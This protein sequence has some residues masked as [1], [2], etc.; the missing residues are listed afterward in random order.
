MTRMRSSQWLSVGIALCLVIGVI[1]L[2]FGASLASAQNSDD[3]PT[4]N[5]TGDPNTVLVGQ[6]E[7]NITNIEIT[8]NNQI[9]ATDKISLYINLSNVEL[10]GVDV[11]SASLSV[12]SIQHGNIT[13]T[14]QIRSEDNTLLRATIRP[15]GTGRA[16]LVNT[17]R[18]SGID[19]SDAK[20]STGVEY[21]IAV[22]S[23][24]TSVPTKFTK[25]L[26]TNPFKIIDG[27]IEIH[28]QATA[29]P[30][31]HRDTRTTAGITIDN[32]SG[33]TNS[34]L[35][36]TR[37]NDN[38]I[39]G[40]RYLSEYVLRTNQAISVNTPYLGGD[41]KG[42]LVANSTLGSTDYDI[43]DHLPSNVT[44]SALSTSEGRIVTASVDLANRSYASSQTNKITIPNA[45]VSDTIEDKTPFFVSL[46]PVNSSGYILQNVT[47]ANSKVLTGW[48]ENVDLYFN[49]TNP[50][51]GIFRSN[52]YAAAIQLSRGLD[53]GNRVSPK[54]YELLRN[55]DLNNQFV[56]D[57]VADAGTILI[58]DSVHTNESN[59]T[60][61]VQIKH[62]QSLDKPV[63]AGQYL[64]YNSSLSDINN[65]ELH[66]IDNKNRSRVVS[67]GTRLNNSS[68][69]K[70]NTSMLTSGT[71]YIHSKRGNS[72][73]FRI[74]GKEKQNIDLQN[75]PNQTS[76]GNLIRF[77]VS[78]SVPSM[79]I[80]LD[81]T[82]N[83]TTT[84]L[85]LTTSE[86]GPT[87]V[88]INAYAS[89]ASPSDFVTTGPGISVD[90][91]TGDT[92]PLSPGS[93]DLTLRSEHGTEVAN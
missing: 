67:L 71:Y 32:I 82:T 27:T 79:E 60:V 59:S 23:G 1:V 89:P 54:N 4:L 42:F 91:V 14:S 76:N 38:E 90:S 25:E 37:N 61:A 70:Y 55:S 63:Y 30:Q 80:I 31:L 8:P 88:T 11:S 10:R 5:K 2:L 3:V 13:N 72:E 58:E 22:S 34:T 52:R 44:H 69:I 33:N 9:N 28:D 65:T 73:R 68:Q 53:A 15:D 46:H 93:Y 64:H 87:P 51:S 18:I 35:F 81:K 92:D 49:T 57:G 20:K 78:H 66:R 62:N 56:S 6:S 36:I 7:Q 85:E 45:K 40:I 29:S 43:R 16:I 19:T 83:N 17:A 47:V 77:S 12:D 41:V 39:I 24:S 26:T 84:T 74:I 21:D 86:T 50:N 48:N 75:G